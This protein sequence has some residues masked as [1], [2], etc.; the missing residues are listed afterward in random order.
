M[1]PTSDLIHLP[2][3]KRDANTTYIIIRVVI[4]VLVAA[5]VIT[6]GVLVYLRNKRWRYRQMHGAT[7]GVNRVYG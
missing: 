2:L 3:Q 1:A 5:A 6:G 7:D 4:G